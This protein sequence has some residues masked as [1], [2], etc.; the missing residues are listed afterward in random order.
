MDFLISPGLLQR[1]QAQIASGQFRT[2]E[3]VLREAMDTLERRQNG[4]EELRRKVQ[5]ADADLTA[6]RAGPFDARQTKLAVREQLRAQGITDG[7]Q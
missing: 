5:E 1:I 3:D 4:L 7:C 2:E 6:G